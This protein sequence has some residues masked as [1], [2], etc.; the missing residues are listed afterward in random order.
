MEKSKKPW[1]CSFPLAWEMDVVWLAGDK[2]DLKRRPKIWSKENSL[3]LVIK[4]A[5]MGSIS[6]MGNL[7]LRRS[8]Y[9]K[10]SKHHALFTLR[11]LFSYSLYYFP[12]YYSA[13][14]GQFQTK[15]SRVLT[16]WEALIKK[17]LNLATTSIHFKVRRIY[18]PMG[19]PKE[20]KWLSHSATPRRS[21]K[22]SRLQEWSEQENCTSRD[23]CSLAR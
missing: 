8:H 15:H 12:I 9:M 14:K 10:T 7:C 21:R 18:N 5:T 1:V 16:F 6:R 13:P 19:I 20:L 3:F 2:P 23:L 11:F 17:I 22:E 4:M